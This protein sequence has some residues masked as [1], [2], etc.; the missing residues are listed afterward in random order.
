MKQLIKYAAAAGM[1]A[2][3]AASVAIAQMPGSP[4]RAVVT[5]YHAAPGQQVALIH[6]LAD[7]DRIAVAAGIAGS[8]QLYVHTDG[9]SWDFMT[10]RPTTTPAQDDAVDAAARK[11]GLPSGPRVGLELRKYLASHTDT[12]T[13]GPIT[14]AQ[15]LTA[16]G[17]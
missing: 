17:S 13:I 11:M 8:T 3:A 15:Y 14:P 4:P 12:Y 16:V 10:I 5:L 7:Q 6:W 1:G 9:D 2:L